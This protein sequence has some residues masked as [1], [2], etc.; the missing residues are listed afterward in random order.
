MST[1]AYLSIDYVALYC[2]PVGLIQ[3]SLGSGLKTDFNFILLGDTI[4]T[5]LAKLHEHWLKIDYTRRQINLY[6]MFFADFS[7]NSQPIFM[8]FCKDYFRVLR[9]LP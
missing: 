9:R 5:I 8:K 7:V 4:Q 1:S 3:F 6:R 2:L